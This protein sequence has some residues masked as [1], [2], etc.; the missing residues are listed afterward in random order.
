[1]KIINVNFKGM[2]CEPDLVFITR[3]LYD[4]R[5]YYGESTL[6]AAITTKKVKSPANSMLLVHLEN[7]VLTYGRQACRNGLDIVYPIV[8]QGAA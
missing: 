4:L 1:M 8:K 2:D 6:L 5:R 7:L 3:R